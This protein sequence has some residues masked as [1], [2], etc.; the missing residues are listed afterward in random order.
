MSD[1][2]PVVI[3]GHVVAYRPAKKAAKKTTAKAAEDKQAA[4][5]AET[6]KESS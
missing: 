6:N 5:P 1:T 4:K 3:G 2:V